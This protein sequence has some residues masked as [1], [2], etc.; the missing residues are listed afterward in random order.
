MKRLSNRTWIGLMLAVCLVVSVSTAGFVLS[1][2]KGSTAQA[3]APGIT[4]P[5]PQPGSAQARAD[6]GRMQA[7]LNGGSVQ[8]QAAL[9]APPLTFAPG[10]GPVV[11]AGK[12]V[13]I[14][15]GTLHS[16]GKFGTVRASISDG[17]AVTLG[18]YLV[19]GHWRL[20]GVQA[21]S[22]QTRAEVTTHPGSPAR[23]RLAAA[24]SIAAQ[25]AL[26][27]GMYQ[28][29]ILVHGFG[30]SASN[31]G[32][33]G[34]PSSM[35]AKISAI[36]GVQVLKF[37]YSQANTKWVD[38]PASGPALA[39]YIHSVARASGRP[40]I[41]VGFSM[42]GL[43]IRYAATEE[44]AGR[45]D[46]PAGRLPVVRILLLVNPLD[47]TSSYDVEYEWRLEADSVP[48]ALSDGNYQLRHIGFGGVHVG[49]PAAAA[50]VAA[51]AAVAN[52]LLA[53]FE[54]VAGRPWAAAQP[55]TGPAAGED[56]HTLDLWV[57]L[58][59]GGPAG[60]TLHSVATT[61]G[62]AMADFRADA[63]A[64]LD[65]A[66]T[67]PGEEGD[68]HLVA[69]SRQGRW[70]LIPTEVTLRTS[71][72]PA[73]GRAWSAGLT[74]EDLGVGVTD[75]GQAVLPRTISDGGSTS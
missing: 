64:P 45:L 2:N 5:T 38:N 73:G 70:V 30:E 42:G 36:P 3:A 51:T 63:A 11:S 29:V 7:L 13:T 55:G 26:E 57:G 46:P 12:T 6:L 61:V 1:L 31:W 60:T 16:E 8:A 75:D 20:Y 53:E 35:F 21:G 28:G 41:V 32:S 14:R 15:P 67:G 52:R 49:A 40:V 33:A 58:G 37:D 43:A 39:D 4:T 72:L 22:A 74:P 50:M 34:D 48:F 25:A 47:A 68:G 69:A 27:A 65:W 10:S 24:V 56:R 18:L 44:R 54:A 59:P 71:D 19:Q 17:T 9:L 62:Q 23:A 66:E